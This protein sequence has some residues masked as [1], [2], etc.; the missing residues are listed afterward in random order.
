MLSSL[1]G[2][3][4]SSMSPNFVN[5]Y[6]SLI[7]G[8]DQTKFRRLISRRRYTICHSIRDLS[9]QMCLNGYRLISPILLSTFIRFY[10]SIPLAFFFQSFF[11]LFPF[12]LLIVISDPIVS[13]LLTYFSSAVNVSSFSNARTLRFIRCRN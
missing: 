7:Q 1:P 3:N 12:F 10:S 8:I 5:K 11:V 13:L 2:A 9:R 6:L 4:R